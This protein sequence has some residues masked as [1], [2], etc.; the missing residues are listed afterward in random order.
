[1]YVYHGVF[2]LCS[3]PVFRSNAMFQFVGKKWGECFVRNPPVFALLCAL[4][5]EEDAAV[6]FRGFPSTFWLA[7]VVGWLAA[8]VCVCW[9]HP[10]VTITNVQSSKYSSSC[11]LGCHR[12]DRAS[13]VRDSMAAMQKDF[14]FS[15]LRSGLSK[16]PHCF[17]TYACYSP[18]ALPEY[19]FTWS[20]WERL[21]VVIFD[22]S[23][24]FHYKGIRVFSCF[25]MHYTA[26]GSVHLCH[27]FHVTILMG[28]IPP[29][30]HTEF[31]PH[32]D[33]VAKICFSSVSHCE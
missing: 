9:R 17:Q 2:W 20:L 4:A 26:M 32:N 11:C 8:R 24:V 31:W 12:R 7:D 10:E 6:T 13:S 19:T 21:S 1:M 3:E 33:F 25:T 5:R 28:Y 27:Q 22:F 15:S 23:S 14:S 30:L 18:N 16:A 29:F